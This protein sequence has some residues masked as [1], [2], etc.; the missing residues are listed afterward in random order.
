[1]THIDIDSTCD[2]PQEVT[3]AHR[4]TVIPTYINIGDRTD[5]IILA[6]VPFLEKV[7]IKL[8][9]NIIS[10]LSRGSS[11]IPV[12]QINCSFQ[13]SAD[14]CSLISPAVPFPGIIKRS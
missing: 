9:G 8:T 11:V 14:C 13:H 12:I 10:I 5:K 1:M 3:N 7:K 4:I 6:K 2:I